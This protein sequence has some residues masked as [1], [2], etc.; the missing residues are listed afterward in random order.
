MRRTQVSLD[1]TITQLDT[2]LSAR[3]AE[4]IAAIPVPEPAPVAEPVD[5]GPIQQ[6]LA[7]LEDRV[8]ALGAGAS[9]ADATALAQTISSMEAEIALAP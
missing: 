8:T 3:R 4:A 9:S 2:G 7:A 1:A 6:Q 5:L